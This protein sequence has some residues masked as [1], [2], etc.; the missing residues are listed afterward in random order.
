V[1]LYMQSERF[2]DA[3]IELEQLL[4]E[5]PDLAYLKDLVKELHQL[6]AQRLLKEIELRRDPGQNRLAAATLP[7]FPAH[8]AAGETLPKVP[9]MLD[10]VKTQQDQGHKVLALL[11]EHMAALK[12]NSTRAELKGIVAEIETD[13]NIN[14]LDRMADYLRLADDDKKPAEQKLSLAISGW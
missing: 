4:K 7:H 1:R 5:F 2:Q 11:K 12:G 14:T 8:G 10:E 13:L 6:G 3:R 9:E